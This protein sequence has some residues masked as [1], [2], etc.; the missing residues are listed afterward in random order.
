MAIC[1]LE[2]LAKKTQLN[3]LLIDTVQI[4][5]SGFFENTLNTMFRN[6]TSSQN[7]SITN[8]LKILLEIIRGFPFSDLQ[9]GLSTSR[10]A[11]LNIKCYT[12]IL[13]SVENE[14]FS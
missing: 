13:S 4:A 7:L 2:N 14:H 12:Q 10:Q 1:G 11:T 8:L 5:F 9:R 3:F 6:S